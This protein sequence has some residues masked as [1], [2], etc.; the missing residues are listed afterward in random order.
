MGLLLLALFFSVGRRCSMHCWATCAGPA[1]APCTWTNLARRDRHPGRLR[2]LP[3]GADFFVEYLIHR[4]QHRFS[5]WW[6]LH[7]LHHYAR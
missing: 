2:D 6:S 7:A 5:W 4:G 1:G 3:G